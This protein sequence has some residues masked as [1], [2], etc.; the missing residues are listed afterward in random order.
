MRYTPP[1][2]SNWGTIIYKYKKTKPLLLLLLN[3]KDKKVQINE[4]Y[5]NSAISCICT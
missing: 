3:V 5:S 1:I 4:S 2:Q